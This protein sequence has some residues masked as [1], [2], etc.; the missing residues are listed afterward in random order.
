MQIQVTQNHP[1]IKIETHFFKKLVEL[2][3]KD[4]KL[5]AREISVIFCGKKFMRKLHKNYLNKE[6]DTDVITFNLSDSEQVEGEIYIS[7]DLAKENALKFKVSEESEL[8]RLIIH[9]LLHLKGYEDSTKIGEKKMRKI[10]NNYLQKF[11]S[12]IVQ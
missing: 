4:E 10:E 6:S 12:Q 2:V 8:S 5:S 11:T 1:L 7:L 9:G 3:L